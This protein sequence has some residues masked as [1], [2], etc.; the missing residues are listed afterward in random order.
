MGASYWRE[1]A[2]RGPRR[3]DAE[4]QR[5]L[6]CPDDDAPLEWSARGE[7]LVCPHCTRSFSQEA[8]YLDAL[9]SH[10]LYALSEGEIATLEERLAGEDSPSTE[11]DP[12]EVYG[13]VWSAVERV[14]G[15]VRGKLILDA[16]CGS[17]LVAR[18]LAGRGARAVAL[19]VARGPGGLDSL[20][21]WRREKPVTLEITRADICRIPFQSATFDFVIIARGI[22]GLRR[23]ERCAMEAS[24]VLRD[25]GKVLVLGE[26]IGRNAGAAIQGG[27]PRARGRALSLADYAGIFSEGRMSLQAH[28]P[29]APPPG[30]KAGLLSRFR[31]YLRAHRAGEDRLLVAAHKEALHLPNPWKR[32]EE[33]GKNG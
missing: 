29:D 9:P 30:R 16:C 15:D 33:H 27:D 10:D 1:V 32:K 5:S 23:P 12:A 13:P 24:R 2:G 28:F 21:A 3:M 8:G 26:E 31:H 11:A 25:G 19:D 14:L 7:R 18:S 22:G 4:I 17:G 6:I 20:A